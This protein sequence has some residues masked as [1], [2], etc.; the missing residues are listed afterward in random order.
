MKAAFSI[1]HF[2]PALI[3]RVS[4]QRETG[5]VASAEMCRGAGCSAVE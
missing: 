3:A 1:Q 2:D 5:P 4:S